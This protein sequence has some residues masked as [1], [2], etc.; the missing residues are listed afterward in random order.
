MTQT[1]PTPHAANKTRKHHNL[2]CIT[3]FF[4]QAWSGNKPW[5]IRKDDREFSIGDIVTLWEVDYEKREYTERCFNN[6]VTYKYEGVEN[7]LQEG[8]CILTLLKIPAQSIGMYTQEEN[9]HNKTWKTLLNE[10]D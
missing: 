1:T 4:V 6:I 5:E 10:H 8:Y 3:H 9:P 2:K 7:G